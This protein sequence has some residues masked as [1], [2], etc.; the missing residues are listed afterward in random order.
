MDNILRHIICINTF[1]NTC[2]NQADGV[3]RQ[4]PHFATS[5]YKST[6]HFG[7]GFA[8]DAPT[9]WNDLPDDEHLATSLQSVQKEAQNLSLCTST[10]TLISAFP[11]FL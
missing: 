6:K 4:V 3:F 9:I 8:C 10:S 2:K 1:Y 11:V 7:L 5:V